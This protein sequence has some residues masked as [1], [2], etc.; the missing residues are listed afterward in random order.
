VSLAYTVFVS[1]VFLP[2]ALAWMERR[3]HR[4]RPLAGS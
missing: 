3:Q 1:L 4:A 2:A